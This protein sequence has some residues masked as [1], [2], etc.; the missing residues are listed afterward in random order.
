MTTRRSVPF[1]RQGP[2][3]RTQQRSGRAGDFVEVDQQ[4]TAAWLQGNLVHGR[5][6]GVEKVEKLAVQDRVRTADRLIEAGRDH[7]RP[8]AQREVVGLGIAQANRRSMLS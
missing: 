8:P 1:S 3:R 2:C 7:V 6:G 5:E 4:S